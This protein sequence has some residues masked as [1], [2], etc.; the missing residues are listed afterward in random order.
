M[1]RYDLRLGDSRDVL[2]TLAYNSVDSCVCDPPYDLTSINK[3]FAK[4]G[5]TDKTWSKSGPHQRTA[6]G[7]MNQKWDTGETAFSP[8]FW[9]EV[10]RV[11]KP[12]GHLVAF[13]GTRTFHRL[14]TA[15]EAAG[16]EVRDR[17]RYECSA[18]TKYA[19]LFDSLT[20][21]Q[22]GAVLELLNDQIGLGSE[23]SWEFG[24]GFPKSHDA[25]NGRGTALKP[26]YEPIYVARKPMIG[27]VAENI[28]EYGTGAINIDPC[29]VVVDD[30]QY[31]RNCS[32]DRGHDDNRSRVMA[33]GMT[34]GK[35][36]DIGRW[37]A[38]LIHDGSDEV[39][40]LFPAAAGQKAPVS[41]DEPSDS[42]DV[43]YGKFDR[44]PAEPR[45]LGGSAARF[46]YCAKASRADRE[47]GCEHLADSVLARSNL[48]QT[49]ESDGDI[50]DAESGGYNKARKRK[51]NHPTVKPTSLM[52]YLCRLVTPA[53]GVVLDPFMGSGSTGKA[54][55]LEGLRFIG[56]EREEHYME[57]A[58]ARVEFGALK[59]AAPKAMPAP[60]ALPKPKPKPV[61][62][63]P[64]L[65]LAA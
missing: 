4:V 36:S 20:D 29:R 59:A 50:V 49:L 13:G 56:I 26:A 32:G 24:S 23:I 19:A 63:L 28:A 34:A 57:I 46:F 22:A 45:D 9:A 5:R 41:G 55:M 54:A 25:G 47:E 11:L 10:L 3:R 30:E 39:L 31:A 38:N 33:F 52:A 58:R 53:G 40:S 18:E 21:D 65:G 8:E 27:T 1:S 51:N 15:I 2:K 42:T 37:P 60:R 61:A 35:A 7:F 12:G 64:L 16:F 17:L 62:S 48:A 43:V 14:V 6:A 44:A